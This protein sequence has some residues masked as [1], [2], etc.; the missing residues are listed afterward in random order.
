MGNTHD[1]PTNQSGRSALVERLK[2]PGGKIIG[3][4]ALLS[5]IITILGF[6][7]IN[8]DTFKFNSIPILSFLSLGAFLG[9]GLTMIFWLPRRLKRPTFKT[10]IPII[11]TTALTV[12]G[13]IA[14]LVSLVQPNISNG[15]RTNDRTLMESVQPAPERYEVKRDGSTATVSGVQMQAKSCPRETSSFAITALEQGD[16][17]SFSLKGYPDDNKSGSYAVTTRGAGISENY[18]ISNG[19]ILRIQATAQKNGDLSIT[20]SSQHRPE[21]G[22]SCDATS[23]V[24]EIDDAVLN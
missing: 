16:R 15:A 19:A 14:L 12:L 24:I 23:E 6:F 7:N 13:V 21:L 22:S 9:A 3:T 8:S 17:V 2:G 10:R 4:L 5:S 11:I 20:I 1:G 18:R